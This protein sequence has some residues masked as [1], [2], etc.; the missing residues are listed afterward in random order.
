MI[1]FMQQL[2]SHKFALFNL[3]GT[4]VPVDKGEYL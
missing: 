1:P 3:G 4:T 2:V